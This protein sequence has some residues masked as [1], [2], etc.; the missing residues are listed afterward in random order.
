MS[1][2]KKVFASNKKAK[3]NYEILE[4]FSAGISLK[5]IEAKSIQL[6]KVSILESFISVKDTD[7]LWKQ[8]Y[9]NLLNTK[10]KF[11]KVE[12][13]RDRRLLLRK[14]EI[15]RIREAV[16][17]SGLTCVPL[18]IYRENFGKIKMTIGI[19]KGKKLYDKR[20]SLKEKSMQMDIKREIKNYKG[21]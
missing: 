15:K 11:E 13:T 7:V 2:N 16:L 6:S 8:G 10:D 1:E 14:P 3:F 17:V 21:E 4:T 5:G 12:E 20:E 19:A 9:I 18:E